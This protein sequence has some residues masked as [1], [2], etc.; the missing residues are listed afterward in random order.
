MNYYKLIAIQVD[1]FESSIVFEKNYSSDGKDYTFAQR[2]QRELN[3]QGYNCLLLAV[4][5][6]LT[7]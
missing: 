6:E 1:D 7:T 5:S 4:E 3:N 2:K